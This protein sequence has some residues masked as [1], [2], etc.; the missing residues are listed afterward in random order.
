MDGRMNIYQFME[1]QKSQG[2]DQN[3]QLS[4]RHKSFSSQRSTINMS[5]SQ[6][7]TNNFNSNN[8]DQYQSSSYPSSRP[9][10]NV[11]TTILDI[12]LRGPT[13]IYIQIV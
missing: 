10:H 11:H 12:E 1:I 3:N 9:Y 13:F 8:Q 5:S 7:N 4:T 6:Y 2:E